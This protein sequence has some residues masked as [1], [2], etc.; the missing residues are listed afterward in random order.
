[1]AEA[2]LPLVLREELARVVLQRALFNAQKRRDVF[3][4]IPLGIRVARWK[5]EGDFGPDGLNITRRLESGSRHK[6]NRRA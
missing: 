4:C 1:M 3:D 5:L 2:E 6:G